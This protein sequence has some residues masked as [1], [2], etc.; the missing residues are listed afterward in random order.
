MAILSG[1]LYAT[2]SGIVRTRE[3]AERA[4]ARD[5]VAHQ[6]LS[7]MTQ[8]ISGRSVTVTLGARSDDED[9]DEDLALP[10]A[11]AGA[12][13]SPQAAPSPSPSA[14]PGG[15]IGTTTFILGADRG[16]P[17]EPDDLLRFVTESGSQGFIG[18]FINHGLVEVEYRL[19]EDPENKGREGKKLGDRTV[20]MLIREER[21]AAAPTAE[22]AAKRKVVVPLAENV[23]GLN[24][25]YLKDGK[26]LDM[27]KT[28]SPPLPEAVEV[29]LELADPEGE[30]ETFRTAIYVNKR[31]RRS[32]DTPP[33]SQ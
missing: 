7:R 13:G 17:E 28:Q 16:T 2:I 23:T 3:I 25:R 8:E 15:T 29:T 9:E 20:K 27:W 24:F 22:L 11:A 6:L 5:R 32:Q 31:P 18:G 30:L 14:F 21:P 33:A 1:I 4:L 26:W 19:E 12:G 10:G